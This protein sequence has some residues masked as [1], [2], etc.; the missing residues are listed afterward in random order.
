MSRPISA[1]PDSGV[2][3][4]LDAVV[5]AG[6][7]G[8]TRFLLDGRPAAKPYL[9]LGGEPLVQRAVGAALGAS[10]IGHVYV[11][12]DVPALSVALAPLL[13]RERE[14]LHLVPEA[15]D[16]V[17]NAY[18]AFFQ[19]VLP[20]RGGPCPRSSSPDPLELRAMQKA[21]PAFR[22]LP[23]LVLTSDLPFI[24]PQEIDDFIAAVPPDAALGLGLLDHRE[25][26][27]MQRDLGEETGLE[28]W[29]WGALPLR[30][31]PVRINNLFLVR[32]LLADPSLYRLLGDVYGHRWLLRQDG[33]VHTR[34]WWAIARAVMRYTSQARRKRRFIRG[35]VNFLPAVIAM[36]LARAAMRSKRVLAWPFRQFLSVHDLEF[37]GSALGDAQLRLVV[38]RELGPAIDIDVPESYLNLAA[39]GEENY[40][41]VA[42]YLAR[43]RAEAVVRPD[44]ALI[45]G[46]KTP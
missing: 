20:G 18:R 37:I 24:H 29:K 13:T 45:A 22:E 26:T 25:L 21:Q 17:T 28:Q 41:R 43:R 8:T 4:T 44:L 3:E 12:G 40:Y 19:H 27:R 15:D 30:R 31:H 38:R 23:A 1:R 6:T 32:P 42:R 9:Q 2:G 10:R 36:G 5:L 46:G 7:R 34:N 16:I 14:R 11:V 39:E 35:L 33:S